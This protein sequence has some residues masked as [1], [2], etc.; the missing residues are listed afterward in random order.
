[1]SFYAPA[2][3]PASA[4]APLDRAIG[5]DPHDP[6]LWTFYHDRAEACVATNG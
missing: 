4:L 3:D 6:H 2:G 5:L 1:L